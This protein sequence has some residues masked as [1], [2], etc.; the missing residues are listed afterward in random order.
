MKLR[1][2][3]RKHTS[4]GVQTLPLLEQTGMIETK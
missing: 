1:I 4:D 2:L 3:D